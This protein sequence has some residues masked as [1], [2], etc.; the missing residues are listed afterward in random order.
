MAQGPTALAAFSRS[1]AALDS[2]PLWE[3]AP[4]AMQPGTDGLP[5]LWRY[6]ELRPKLL[7]AT[8]LI[9]TDEAERRVLVLENPGLRGSGFVA[10]TLYAGLQI[11]LPG[12]IAR[13]HR[14]SPAALRFLLEG[15]GG[16]TIVEGK[17]VEM[18]FG[19]FVV[20]PSWS[21][22]AHGHEGNGPVVWLDGLDTPMARLFG[23]T[24]RE[25]T[26][27]VADG[28]MRQEEEGP[29]RLLHYPYART[30]EALSRLARANAPHPS[31]G[32]RLRYADPGRGG[33]V[34][35]TMAAFLQLLPE[36]FAG[37]PARST[38][39]QMFAVVEGEGHVEMA[40]KSFAFGPR[41]MFVVPSW[42]RYRFAARRETVLFSFSDRAAQE[43]LGFWREETP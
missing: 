1:L 11:I 36:G 15:E 38:E 4:G 33:S 42:T 2:V 19:D 8:R 10:T 27:A 12:E 24:F 5:R 14:H 31:Q 41:D 39:A 9:S 17:R 22:H 37:T 29:A 7:E 30:Y 25:D 18:G 40:G 23:A 28:N 16:H 43:A 20:T 3:R 21:W 32:F 13:P 26:P 6:D 35:P 34:F